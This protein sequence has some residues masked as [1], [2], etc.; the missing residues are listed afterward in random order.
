MKST[1]SRRTFVRAAAG[2]GLGL[3]VRREALAAT[4]SPASKRIGMIGLD[5]SHCEVFTKMINNAVTDNPGFKVTVAYH[6]KTNRDVLNVA[7]SVSEQLAKLGVTIVDNLP[8]L[9]DQCDAVML[10]SIDGN[11]HLSQALPVLEARKRLFIDK[12]LAA[13]LQGAKAIV[14]ASEQYATPFFSSSSLRFDPNVQKVVS[15]AVGK[16]IGA[17]VYTPATIDEQH[18]DLAWYAIHGL[19]ML[20]TVMGPGCK[21]IRRIYTKDTD[22]ITGIWTDGRI[23]TLRGVRDWPVGIAGTAF[24]EK[25][26]APLG[27]FSEQ[28]YQQLVQQIL[29]F[30]DT[31]KPPVTPAETLEIFAFMQAAD[32]SRK[33]NGAAVKIHL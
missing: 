33:K 15:G 14:E 29:H 7:P 26:T 30:F 17:D 10:E 18:S 24:G 13:S 25:G 3:S 23:G 31:G 12:P 28:A 9:L 2:I 6:P 32:K 11:G 27:L 19:E 20:Y 21:E 8:A 5:T 1:Y 16:V 22:V 4:F